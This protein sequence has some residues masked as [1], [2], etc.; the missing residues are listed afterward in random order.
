MR[1][2]AGFAINFLIIALI[3]NI[4]KA[5]PWYL[6]VS[7]LASFCGGMTTFQSVCFS[8]ISDVTSDK[9]RGFR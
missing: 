3:C 7:S 9:D 6:L 8:Y 1:N 4:P 5:S 2:F